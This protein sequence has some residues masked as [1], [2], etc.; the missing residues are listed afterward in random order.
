MCN[1][2]EAL[3]INGVYCHELGCPDAWQDKIRECKWCGQ[4]FKPEHSGQTCCDDTCH[5]AYNGAPMPGDED[6]A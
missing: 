2:C 6:Q 3:M 1:S 4:D 5:A